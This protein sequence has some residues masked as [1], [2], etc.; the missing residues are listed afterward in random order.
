MKI[1]ATTYI[2]KIKHF[3]VVVV[4]VCF[5]LLFL[6]LFLV[7]VSLFF[8]FVFPFFRMSFHRFIRKH[9]KLENGGLVGKQMN[10]AVIHVLVHDLNAVVNKLTASS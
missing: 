1:T 6:F 4:S 9:R 10:I 8:F 5:V 7:F 3:F 2:I